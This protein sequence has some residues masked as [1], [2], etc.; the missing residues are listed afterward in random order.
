VESIHNAK[1]LPERS[2]TVTAQN[3]AINT[4]HTGLK[5]NLV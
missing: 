2:S 1:N 4:N 5:G 3:P